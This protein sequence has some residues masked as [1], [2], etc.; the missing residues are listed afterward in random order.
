MKSEYKI[1][2]YLRG[3]LTG[4]DANDLERTALSDMF[5][6]EALEGYDSVDGQHAGTI[7]SCW[8]KIKKQTHPHA[9]PG[10]KTW[11]IAI[12]I[13]LLGGLIVWRVGKKNEPQESETTTIKDSA[14][15]SSV[16][17]YKSS[18]EQTIEDTQKVIEGQEDETPEPPAGQERMVTDKPIST[19]NMK[20]F[21]KYV[22]DSMRYPEDARLEGVK[23]E[24]ELTFR[25]NN[26]G[27]PSEILIVRG[28]SA[29]CNRE[30]IR[31]LTGGPFWA[32]TGA[33]E[34]LTIV[35]DFP[36]RDTSRSN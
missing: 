4:Q 5:L 24:V 26:V 17:A 20:P 27:C 28:L 31:L 34:R 3:R 23:G 9:M 12:L 35:M 25:V 13:L 32:P 33:N 11:G 16:V 15:S 6:Y 22:R 30:A 21:E 10:L 18:K 36:N 19:V 29:S 14:E 1:S 8:Q 7:D 2:D